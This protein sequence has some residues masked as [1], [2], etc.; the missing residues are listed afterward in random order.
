MTSLDTSIRVAPYGRITA[1]GC[2]LTLS[3][4]DNA[5]YHVRLMKG[6][7]VLADGYCARNGTMT[8]AAALQRLTLNL[9]GPT[10]AI[11]R[12]AEEFA[13]LAEATAV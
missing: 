13:K 4:T 5:R 2:H 1:C 8:K 6:D 9:F 12:V 3:Y 7:A 11:Y 10:T